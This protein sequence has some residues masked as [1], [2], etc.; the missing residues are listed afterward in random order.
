[1]A[2]VFLS[3]SNVDDRYVDHLA[4]W[5]GANG[6]SE[7]FI[8]HHDIAGGVK[9]GDALRRSAGACRV[10]LCLVTENWLSSSNCFSEY[11]SAWYMG[12]RVIPLFA[13]STEEWLDEEATE[14]LN[15]IRSEFQGVDLSKI[16]GMDGLP[17]FT[18]DPLTEKL[19]ITGLRAAGALSRVGLDPEAF[20]IDRTYRPTPFP[21]LASYN[22]ADADAA[23]FYGRS[24]ETAGVIEELRTMRA[25]SDR[26]PLIILGASGA[27]KSSLL[28]AGVIPRL[29]RETPGWAPLRAF[30]PGVD[31]LSNFADALS[32]SQND[33]GGA[34]A[35]GEIRNRLFAA[36]RDAPRDEDGV[37]SEA[38]REQIRAALEAE[39]EKLR[40]VADRPYAT[41]LISVDQAEE[42]PRSENNSAH[43]MADYLRA[44]IDSETEW[45]LAFTIRA[46]SFR[47]LQSHPMFQ[48][49]EARGYDLRSIAVFHFDNL[50]E[51]PAQRYGVTVDPNLVRQLVADAPKSDSLPL[52]SF[53]LERLWAQFAAKGA[54]TLGDYQSLGG[55]T[56]LIAGA[57]EAA[58][59]GIEP[60]SGIS[61]ASPDPSE[62]DIALGARTFV[63]ALASVND[64]GSATRRVADLSEFDDDSRK[65]LER[66]ARWRLVVLK[67][68]GSGAQRTTVEVAHEAIFREW[69]RL[70]RWM[71][72]ERQNLSALRGLSSAAE[73]WDL[74]GRKPIL[75]THFG[76]RLR[77][78]RRLHQDPRYQ[79]L[80]DT[81]E[82]EYLS[83]AY[84]VEKRKRTI[85]RAVQGVAAALVLTTAAGIAAY[86][87]EAEIRREWARATAFTQTE[88][89]E[90]ATLADGAMFQECA[91]NIPC[92][93]MVKIPAG[94][95]VMG[96]N[97]D[98]SPSEL[99]RR[100]V[101]MEP[102]AASKFEITHDQWDY[103]VSLTHKRQ[104]RRFDDEGVAFGCEPVGD[105]GFGRDD[106]PV[107]NVTWKQAKGYV[108]W[109]NYMTT[110][111]DGAAPYRLLSETEWE[112][113]A[114]GGTREVYSWGDSPKDACEYANLANADTKA[115]YKFDWKAAPCEDGF[116]ETAPVGSFKPNPF[117]LYDM[118]GNV[119]EWVADCWHETYEDAPKDQ[120]VWGEENDGDCALAVL[121]GGSWF[122]S[123][124]IPRS[125]HRGEG[126]RETRDGAIGFRV[127]RDLG[128]SP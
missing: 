93:E 127:A 35:P 67:A 92:P 94:R 41:I 121:R 87:Y 34:E 118:H 44:A 9:W 97:I 91:E 114:R 3:H 43:A 42:L 88:A 20:D 112:Y 123:V 58:L 69:W 104:A 82:R 113:A 16:R 56:G 30:R 68:D 5:L 98:P 8:D 46:D 80:I 124:R 49:L 77:E 95:F 65:L 96:G 115:Q 119:L 40:A 83:S 37:L 125:A 81:R 76:P 10:I 32:R 48:G 62:S 84:Q 101:K 45:R 99:P 71:E 25:N 102:F 57:A 78:A 89:A 66:F 70:R 74:G 120:R 122:N 4:D 39:G 19:L 72:P 128:K 126:P 85:Q 108:R 53:S 24:A 111:K 11:L 60:G 47:D 18:R 22:D 109:L 117:G 38:G 106:R 105:R 59:A 73:A 23:V 64:A 50:I 52:L 51:Q 2:V 107:I 79:E 33:Y 13:L 14:R 55:L 21:G 7:V 12:K 110:G 17:D 63:P 90:L 26:R 29:R 100:R 75:L 6:F 86:T 15:N 103:C 28:R 116:R 61:T 54:L 27:G 1:M 36:W 31:P